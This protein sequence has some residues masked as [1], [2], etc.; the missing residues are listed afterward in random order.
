LTGGAGSVVDKN[1][2]PQAQIYDGLLARNLF[3]YR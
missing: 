2:L 1:T 3:R